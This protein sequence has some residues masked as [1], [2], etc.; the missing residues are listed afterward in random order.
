LAQSKVAK[1]I[2]EIKGEQFN[3]FLKLDVKE[4]YP[5]V[6]HAWLEEVLQRKIP[7]R[8]LR[9]LL[10]S[11]V[12]TPSLFASES[13]KNKSN[14]RGIPQGLAVSNAL[15]ELSVAHL[16]EAMTQIDDTAYFRYVDDILVLM[17]S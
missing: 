7:S 10:M 12:K 15:A 17:K 8:K 3:Y 4:F 11:A 14:L 16:D 6:N 1:V 2:A 13:S 5:S 9:T